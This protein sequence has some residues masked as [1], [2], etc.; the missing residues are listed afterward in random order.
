VWIADTYPRS[1]LSDVQGV[2]SWHGRFRDVVI[3]NNCAKIERSNISPAING[4]GNVSGVDLKSSCPRSQNSMVWSKLIAY[5]SYMTATRTCCMS[6]ARTPFIGNPSAMIFLVSLR[7]H[8][9]LYELLSRY[10][11]ASDLQQQPGPETQ[12]FPVLVPA[13]NI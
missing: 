11:T 8:N 1:G 4:T 7:L 12:H 10:H 3:W 2:Q 5:D 6:D 9:S 13:Q